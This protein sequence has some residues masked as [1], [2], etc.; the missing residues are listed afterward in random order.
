MLCGD[1]D[2]TS[3][4]LMGSTNELAQFAYNDSFGSEE[5]KTF[6]ML[7]GIGHG[8]FGDYGNPEQPV[9]TLGRE[10][11]TASIRHYLLAW[12]LARAYGDGDAFDNLSL[13]SQQ[14]SSTGTFI[15]TMVAP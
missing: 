5:S 7:N 15:T 6:V 12:L 3:V 13:D 11:V 4:P 10:P 9:G 8:G 1:E 2:D 14:P